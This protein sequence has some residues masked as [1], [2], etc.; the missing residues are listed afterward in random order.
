MSV[1]PTS[2]AQ[3]RIERAAIRLFSEKG[4]TRITMQEL[5]KEAGVARGTVY[6]NIDST[7]QLFEATAARLSGEMLHRVSDTLGR[8]ED[9]AVALS[10]NIRFFVRRAHEQPDWGRFVYRFGVSDGSL[11]Y[12]LH[13]AARRAVAKGI[14]KGR[15]EIREDLLESVLSMT[16]GSTLTAMW[17][18]I[19]GHQTW[20]EA[21]S[22]TSELLLRALGIP[23]D[24]ARTIS[25]L[26]LPP[27][28]AD[29]SAIIP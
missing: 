16:L 7:E 2:A 25:V 5:A 28:A 1:Q 14:R 17:L 4:N 12:L 8:V 6:N 27:L 18:V 11:R 3:R 19:E 23:A 26:E 24:E 20:R 15:Y 21:G 13:G 10:H 29:G 9:P 22:A